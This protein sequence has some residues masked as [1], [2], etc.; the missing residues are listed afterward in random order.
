MKLTEEDALDYCYEEIS[1]LEERLRM[2]GLSDQDIRQI[3]IRLATLRSRISNY[4]KPTYRK[5]NI[6]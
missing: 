3:E 4:P 5:T 1:I 6:S 2:R